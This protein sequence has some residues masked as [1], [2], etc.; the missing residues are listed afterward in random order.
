MDKPRPEP[1]LRVL[2]HIR[3]HAG[4]SEA[5]LLGFL[6]CVRFFRSFQSLPLV[7]TPLLECCPHTLFLL[8]CFVTPDDAILAPELESACEVCIHAI[9]PVRPLRQVCHTRNQC[10]KMRL[11]QI[12][13]AVSVVRQRNH[14]LVELPGLEWE[15][16]IL[17]RFGLLVQKTCDQSRVFGHDTAERAAALVAFEV[18]GRFSFEKTLEQGAVMVGWAIGAGGIRRV[19]QVLIHGRQLH[20]VVTV[21]RL[22]IIQVVLVRVDIGVDVS[23]DISVDLVVEQIVKQF[24]ELKVLKRRSR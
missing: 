4:C 1:K 21:E 13:D 3:H 5:V 20:V 22:E 19:V 9:H 11:S 10:R 14:R 18:L 17:V 7:F 15:S 12:D 2:E 6:C 16:Q 23:V 24:K 8:F